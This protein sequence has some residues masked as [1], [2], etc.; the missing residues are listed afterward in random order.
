ME[1]KINRVDILKPLF[2]DPNKRFYLRELSRILKVNH[3]TVGQQLKQFEKEGIV[4]SEKNKITKTYQIVV[5]RKSRNLKLFF[6]LEKLR[7]SGLVDDLFKEY[8]A[9]TIVLF[10]SYAKAT[11]SI[12]SDID[13]CLLSD[14]KK[15]FNLEKYEKVLGRKISIHQFGKKE[16]ENAIKNNPNLVNGICNGI[17]LTGELEVLK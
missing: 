7:I 1:I 10:G 13:M 8:D 5:S 3:V 17:V 14:I 9:P 6:N 12:D 15:E 16:W 4:N 2:E 11:D